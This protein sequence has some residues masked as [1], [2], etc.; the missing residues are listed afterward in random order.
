M[1]SRLATLPHRGREE[2][3][4]SN[5][6]SAGVGSSEEEEGRGWWGRYEE[7]EEV[8]EEEKVVGVEEQE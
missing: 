6:V 3:R 5:A 8:E 7:M 4:W 1:S 2:E